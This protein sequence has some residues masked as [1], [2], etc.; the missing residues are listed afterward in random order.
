MWIPQ[1]LWLY[2]ISCSIPTSFLYFSFLRDFRWSLFNSIA[3]IVLYK[4]QYIFSQSILRESRRHT[5]DEKWYF[6]LFCFFFSLYPRMWHSFKS[7]FLFFSV[8]FLLC[9]FIY[10]YFRSAFLLSVTVQHI[11]V[12]FFWSNIRNTCMLDMYLCMYIIENLMPVFFPSCFFVFLSFS[13]SSNRLSFSIIFRYCV[14]VA[15]LT[16]KTYRRRK[17]KIMKNT[18]QQWKKKRKDGRDM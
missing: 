16:H 11:C 17:S 8:H 4:I 12:S 18:I 13:S 5:I 7:Y 3:A 2:L 1:Y 14:F 6:M 15:F 9:A 10:L